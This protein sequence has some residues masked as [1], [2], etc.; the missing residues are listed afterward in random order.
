MKGVSIL[1]K[2][3]LNQKNFIKLASYISFAQNMWTSCY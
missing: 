3:A 1:I 2:S